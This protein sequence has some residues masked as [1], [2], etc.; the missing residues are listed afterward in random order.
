[1]QVSTSRHRWAIGKLKK[2]RKITS[3]WEQLNRSRRVTSL[4]GATAKIHQNVADDTLRATFHPYRVSTPRVK[5]LSRKVSRATF[6]LVRR[7]SS[8]RENTDETLSSCVF[9]NDFVTSNFILSRI[10][11]DDGCNVL[12]RKKDDLS[13]SGANFHLHVETKRYEEATFSESRSP[14]FLLTSLQLVRGP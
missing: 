14:I 11:S 5:H 10:Y 12:L 2:G 4:R 6:I 8:L 9:D 3:N 7:T 1:M 13:A